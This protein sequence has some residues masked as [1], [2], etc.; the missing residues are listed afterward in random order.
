[1]RGTLGPLNQSVERYGTEQDRR[2]M[3]S[4]KSELITRWIEVHVQANGGALGS[5]RNDVVNYITR[6]I[7]EHHG[8][9]G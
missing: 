6:F 3:E 4:R 1:M 5:T 7:L 8:M 9:M 2:E